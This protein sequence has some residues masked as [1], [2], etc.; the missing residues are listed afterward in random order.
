MLK[1]FCTLD[2]YSSYV[3]ITVLALKTESAN[4]MAG[5]ILCHTKEKELFFMSNLMRIYNRSMVPSGL[6]D[7]MLSDFFRDSLFTA[8]PDADRPDRPVS[9]FRLDVSESGDAYT[10]YADLPGVAKE[11]VA[12]DLQEGV[13]TIDVTRGEKAEDETAG[14]I[15]RERRVSSMRRRLRLRDAAQDGADARLE[16]GVLT[17]TVPKAVQPPQSSRIL[18]H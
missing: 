2:K 8:E 15:H 5:N 18:I 14:Y 7:A 9:D 3:T 12:L 1:I 13:L 16:N 17:V 10:V 6:F 4:E 11:S